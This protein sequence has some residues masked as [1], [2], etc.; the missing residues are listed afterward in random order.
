MNILIVGLGSIGQRHLRVLKNIYKKKVSFYTLNSTNTNRVIKD[1]FE[2][3]KVRSLCKYYSIKKIKISEVKKYNIIAAYICSPPNLH[4]KT[5]LSL[6]SQNCNLLIEKPLST[7]KEL[8]EIKKL[9]EISYRKKLVIRV[10]YQLRFHPGV[11]IVKSIIE[12]K[13][14][15]N[16]VNGYFHFG[17]YIGAVKK[18]EN[19]L[20]SIYVKQNKG[21]GALLAFSHHLDLAF[22]FFGKLKNK[23]SLLDNSKNFKIDVEDN[24]KIILSDNKKNNF[25]FNLNFLDNPQENF[26]ILNFQSGSLKWDYTKDSL[27]VKKYKKDVTKTYNFKKFKR[28]DLFKEQSNLFFSDIK[29]KNYKNQS[30]RDSYN[31]LKLIYYIKRKNKKNKR[32]KS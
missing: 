31:L 28:N 8:K 3:F 7:D 4:L 2:S 14:C 18:Y 24:C 21:G 32:K 1:N 9:L 25:L 26:F 12:N 11:K 10:G 17:E 5:A 6:V 13:E 27:F 15:G 30:L 16:V 29:F 22:H 19:F 23:Y 20:D